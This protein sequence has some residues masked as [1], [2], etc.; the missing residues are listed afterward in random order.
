MDETAARHARAAHEVHRDVTRALTR[1]FGADAE[2]CVAEA[3]LRV[4]TA[5]TRDEDHAKRLTARTATGLAIDASRHRSVV[6]KYVPRLA[7]PATTESAEDTYIDGEL[8]QRVA[9]AVAELPPL[10]RDVVLRYA[11][12]QPA[13]EIAQQVG[14]SLYSVKHVIARTIRELRQKFRDAELALTGFWLRRRRRASQ[15]AVAMSQTMIVAALPGVA[16]ALSI[17]SP[18][19]GRAAAY[20]LSVDRRP[21]VV[22]ASASDEVPGSDA[23]RRLVDVLTARRR[24]GATHGGG[25]PASQVTRQVEPVLKAVADRAPRNPNVEANAD[26]HHVYTKPRDGAPPAVEYDPEPDDPVG[27]LAYCLGHPVITPERI[28]CEKPSR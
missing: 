11:N 19:A 14:H 26:G 25:D 9:D 6:Q 8:R 4:C 10:Q 16:M 7:A 13:N 12:G 15:A 1:R 28:Y 3:L 17:A 20:V 23:A 21:G 18:L 27:D 5:S 2:D 24:A 22:A